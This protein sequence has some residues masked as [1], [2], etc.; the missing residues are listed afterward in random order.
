MRFK[1]VFMV[2]KHNFFSSK[3]LKTALWC[4]CA[5]TLSLHGK[6][7]ALDKSSKIGFEITKYAILSVDGLF[8]EFSG[9]LE[10]DESGK[11]TALQIQALSASVSTGKAKRDK[12]AR[13]KFL[14]AAQH[15]F[16][17]LS[18]TSYT[19]TRSKGGKQEGKLI[20]KLTLQGK[21]KNIEFQSR[22]DT[23]QATPKLTLTGKFNSEDFGVQSS[24]ARS[25]EVH[26][27]LETKWLAQ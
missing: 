27:I 16:V 15:K 2:T 14:N 25:N 18:F 9:R 5:L 4:L 8:R 20:A 13:E 23:S 21:S 26:L 11:I 17:A 10:L 1:E 24:F 6:D 3:H 7:Y 19:P 12:F 22:L